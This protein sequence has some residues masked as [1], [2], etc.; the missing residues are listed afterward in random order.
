M[1]RFVFLALFWGYRGMEIDLMY[2]CQAWLFG[3]GNDFRTLRGIVDK[4]VSPRRFV[5]V[6]LGFTVIQL[7]LSGGWVY[8]GGESK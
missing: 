8:Y 4:S 2:R 3:Q 5:V 1:K 7:R 6:L